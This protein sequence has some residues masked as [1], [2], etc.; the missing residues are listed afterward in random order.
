[1]NASGKPAP[2][3]PRPKVIITNASDRQLRAAG[4]RKVPE[5]V[6]RG[7]FEDFLK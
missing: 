1:M 7:T 2:K 5:K 4:L 3:T 6:A